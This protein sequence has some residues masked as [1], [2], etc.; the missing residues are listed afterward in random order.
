[1]CVLKCVPVCSSVLQCVD[2]CH[3]LWSGEVR[4]VCVISHISMHGYRKC[5]THCNT[6][7]H[8]ATH[9]NTL[10]HTVT[11]CNTLQ[12]NATRCNALQRTATHCNTLQ[13]TAT[14]CNTLQHTSRQ[15]CCK[16]PTSWA[17]PWCCGSDI[18]MSRM[19]MSHVC[20]QQVTSHMSTQSYCKCPT[21]CNTLQLT[22][23]RCNMQHTA[24]QDYYKCPSRWAAPW[25]RGSDMHLSSRAAP[26]ATSNGTCKMNC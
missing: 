13:R 25:C 23:T 20:Y 4:S 6:L 14:H 15:D 12:H 7:Q 2:A 17:A 18:L 9:C 26:P 11:H 19:G 5:P 1:M 10:Q 22:A 21:H 24:T 3:A 8:T 16:C